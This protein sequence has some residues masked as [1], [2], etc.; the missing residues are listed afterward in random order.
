[1]LRPT[2]LLTL[3]ATHLCAA[4]QSP[5]APAKPLDLFVASFGPGALLL[6]SSADWTISYLG[7]GYDNVDHPQIDF[8]NQKTTVIA[9]F[10]LFKNTSARPDPTWCRKEAVEPALRPRTDIVRRTDTLDTVPTAGGNTMPL[11]LTSFYSPAGKSENLHDLYAFAA[12]AETCFELHLFLFEK[13]GGLK[14]DLQSILDLFHPMPGYQPTAEDE[15]FVASLFAPKHSQ[16]AAPYYKQ[17]LRLVPVTPATLKLRRTIT[18]KLIAAYNGTGD[19]DDA[20]PTAEHAIEDDPTWP[21]NYYNLA[22]ADANDDRLE[23]ARLH[24]E[25]AFAR[26]TNLPAG[27]TMP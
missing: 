22:C 4:Q 3:L 17:S 25:Q 18:D 1:M 7:A 11:A 16:F 24:L 14:L 26:K 15:N 9:A 8:R 27:Q 6:P 20:R 12:D 21:M 19:S 2:L 23:P 10:E 13:S 5:A